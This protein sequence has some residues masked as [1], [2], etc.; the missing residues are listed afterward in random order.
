MNA[1]FIELAEQIVENNQDVIAKVE[2]EICN[3]GC[4]FCTNCSGIVGG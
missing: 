1:K 4:E 2:I 3:I